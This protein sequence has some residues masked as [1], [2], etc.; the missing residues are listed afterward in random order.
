MIQ[1]YF[2]A[3]TVIQLTLHLQKVIYWHSVVFACQKMGENKLGQNF[4]YELWNNTTFRRKLIQHD[5]KTQIYR[6]HSK[7]NG[8]AKNINFKLK[9]WKPC[10]DILLRKI[11]SL[12]QICSYR[13]LNETFYV[14]VLKILW[15]SLV[16]TKADKWI[17]HR[18]QAEIRENSKPEKYPNRVCRTAQKERERTHGQ[19][20]P[21]I[22][23]REV[24]IY[25]P[26]GAKFGK[27]SK[28]RKNTVS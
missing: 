24:L 19:S 10:W 16:E 11:N 18:N 7:V 4:G 8:T 17:S 23:P 5:K 15:S 28:G 2:K 22:T 9:M 6:I 13:T 20:V 14:Q 25:K 27:P 12:L 1:M 3:V 26:E 21:H